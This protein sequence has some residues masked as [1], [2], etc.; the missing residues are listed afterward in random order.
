MATDLMLAA[1]MATCGSGPA[2]E[3]G[4]ATRLIVAGPFRHAPE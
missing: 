3:T 1:L 2:V 4:A